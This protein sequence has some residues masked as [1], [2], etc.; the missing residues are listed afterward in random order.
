MLFPV[1]VFRTSVPGRRA[2]GRLLAELRRHWPAWRITLDVQDC[3]RVLRVQT[4]GET[5]PV[6]AI[7]AE[8]RARGY[9][10]DVLPDEPAPALSPGS[11]PFLLCLPS[12][13]SGK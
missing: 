7:R 3:D 1:E 4:T 11:V 6:G 9:L 2:A 5:V 12:N 10:C 13:N 8:V